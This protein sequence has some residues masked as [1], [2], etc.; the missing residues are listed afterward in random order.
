MI[1]PLECF[2][3]LNLLFKNKNAFR[4][5]S[6]MTSTSYN[7]QNNHPLF[8]HC[9]AQMPISKADHR[10]GLCH[11][12]RSYNKQFLKFKKWLSLLSW[13]RLTKCKVLTF[14][15]EWRIHATMHLIYEFAKESI[16]Y[17]Y[18]KSFILTIYA[19]SF[20]TITSIFLNLCI[21][22]VVYISSWD[23]KRLIK[24]TLTSRLIFKKTAIKVLEDKL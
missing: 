22:L 11:S 16:I 7:R 23:F 21:F 4:H 8:Q 14:L 6:A 5:E 3:L 12:Q 24:W 20:L 17:H 18:R 13:P 2:K 9:T 10:H 1:Q 19:Y 15:L